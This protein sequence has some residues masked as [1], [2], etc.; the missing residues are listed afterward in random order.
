VRYT[1]IQQIKLFSSIIA[2]RVADEVSKKVE[3]EIQL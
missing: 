3:G 1:R 2:F